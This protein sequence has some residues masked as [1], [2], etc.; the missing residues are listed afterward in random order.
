MCTCTH[1]FSHQ[2]GAMH[3]SLRGLPPPEDAGASDVPGRWPAAQARARAQQEPTPKSPPVTT[4]YEVV[5]P[6]TFAGPRSSLTRSTRRTSTVL[7]KFRDSVPP[8]APT[9]RSQDYQTVVVELS[10]LLLDR[11]AC[12]H[13]WSS[14]TRPPSRSQESRPAYC[15]ERCVSDPTAFGLDAA[16]SSHSRLGMA[17]GPQGPV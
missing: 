13:L 6:A 12:A 7:H 14:T 10:A 8:S 3:H 15:P 9:G 4:C 5:V 11:D 1:E 16:C 2:P 17:A